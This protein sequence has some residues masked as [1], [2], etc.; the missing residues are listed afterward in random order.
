VRGYLDQVK[1]IEAAKINGMFVG[2][3]GST[4]E[5]GQERVQLVLSRCYCVA[6]QALKRC[7]WY[8][9]SVAFLLIRF[10][11]RQGVM[12]PSLS[13]LADELFKIRNKLEKLELTQAWSLRETDL[14]D[15]QVFL[16]D[17]DD[18]RVEGKFVGADGS[19]PEEGQSVRNCLFKSSQSV[20]MLTVAGFALFT[21]TVLCSHLHSDEFERG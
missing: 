4:P 7:S 9:S 2:E 5:Q 11:C 8:S 21:E 1:Q 3:D 13:H 10:R 20:L 17:L 15:F 14:Y 16:M 12:A 6:D 18:Q 19:S